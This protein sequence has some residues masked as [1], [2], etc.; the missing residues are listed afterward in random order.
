MVIYFRIV[1]AIS[2]SETIFLGGEL[3]SFVIYRYIWCLIFM[4]LDFVWDSFRLLQIMRE[5][6]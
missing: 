3:V 2:F 5:C 4:D 6:R 1:Q